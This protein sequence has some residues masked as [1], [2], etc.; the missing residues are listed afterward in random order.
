MEIKINKIK[1]EKFKSI[2]IRESY[3]DKLKEYCESKDYKIK[4]VIE[5]LIDELIKGDLDEDEV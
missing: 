1:K 3:R 4:D 2:N 5:Y